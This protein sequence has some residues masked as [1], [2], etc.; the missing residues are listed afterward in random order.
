MTAKH[1]RARTSAA[2]TDDAAR[3]LR[4][5]YLRWR[6][7]LPLAYRAAVRRGRVRMPFGRG[8]AEDAAAGFIGEPTEAEARRAHAEHLRWRRSLPLAYRVAWR[9]GQVRMP[10]DR[11]RAERLAARF[12]AGDSDA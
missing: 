1:D 10:V 2:P 12:V 9:R 8:A 11:E 3:L 4:A 6:R 7:S 5:D